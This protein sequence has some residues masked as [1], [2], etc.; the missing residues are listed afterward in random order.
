CLVYSLPSPHGSLPGRRCRHLLPHQRCPGGRFEERALQERSPQPQLHR[1]EGGEALN[2]R[3]S[4]KDQ[5][6][7]E[8]DRQLTNRH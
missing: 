4:Q 5:F 6:S 7:Q 8:Q 1:Q 3:I 2:C